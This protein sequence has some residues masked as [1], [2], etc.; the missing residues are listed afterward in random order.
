MRSSLRPGGGAA[1]ALAAVALLAGTA[2]AQ[3]RPSEQD[4]FGGATAADAGAPGPAAGASAAPP[5]DAAAAPRAVGQPLPASA[6]PATEASGTARDQDMLGNPAAGPKLSADV[7]PENPLTIGGQLYLRAQTTAQQ[8]TSPGD[9]TFF[10]PNLLDVF[11]DARPNDRVRAY[12]LG[13]MSFDPTAAPPVTT[14]PA[15]LGTG[16]GTGALPGSGFSNIG[17]GRGPNTLLD[18]LWISFDVKRRLFVTAGKQHVKWGTGRFWTPTD[19]L[20]PVKRNP[21]DVFDARGGVTM[22]KLHL[23]WEQRAWNFYGFA[24]VEDPVEATGTMSKVAGAARAELVILGAELGLDVFA[25]NGQRPRFGVDL[26]TGLG[27]FDVYVDAGIRF[28]ED[29]LTVTDADPSQADLTMR[30]H[31]GRHDGIKTQ[32]TTGVTWSRKYN[33]NDL[34]TIG[35]EYFYNQVGYADRTL[36]P[37][38]F[39]N[40]ENTPLLNFFYLGR[41]YG[42]LFLALPAPYSWNYTTFTLSTLGNLSDRS[43]VSRLDYSV[44]L[45][46]H[47]SLQAFVGVHYGEAGGELRFVLPAALV[48]LAQQA[49]TMSGTSIDALLNAPVVDLG[50]A[51]RLRI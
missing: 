34:F 8:N 25:K 36:Y 46:T 32:L 6:P 29:F 41:H 24:V 45:L 3:P 12:A 16:T 33:D 31:V 4:L 35:A 39:V 9:W 13:R 27:D 51:L 10:A 28:G 21:L 48:P 22:L 7:A 5:K 44:T 14:M 40:N 2:A 26:S 23:P 1:G 15:V 20:H 38:L 47:L 37:G 49:A 42:A 11:L 50:V 30:Y 43:F 17:R 19:Y 18:Q